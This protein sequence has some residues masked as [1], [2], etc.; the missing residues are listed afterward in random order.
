MIYSDLLDQSI[1]EEINKKAHLLEEEL[2]SDVLFYSGGIHLGYFRVFRD[3]VEKVKSNS[4]REENAISV[5]LRTAGGLPDMAERM[6]SVLRH[7]YES[8]YFVVP[9]FA[10]SAGTILCMSADKIY[11]DYSSSLGPIDPQVP[12]PDGREYVP[13]AGY[14]DKV[15]DLTEKGELAPADV[16]LLK[17]L[18]LARLALY[19]QARDLSID[20]LKKWLVKYKFKNWDT[21]RTD[22]ELKGKDVTVDE[23]EARAEEIALAL[24][25]HKKWFSHGR[26]LNIEKLNDIRIEI[27]DY[28]SETNSELFR[29]IRDYNDLLT[30]YIDRMNLP[31]FLHNRHISI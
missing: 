18:D 2:K 3:F 15:N 27:D 17:T 8:V 11:M 6:V 22:P 7:H 26:L 29:L 4:K 25:D 20:L 10:M 14:L 16:I 24:S 9:D 21:H 23:K 5:F 19:E 30:G 1:F 31:L 28:S 13:A 12:T